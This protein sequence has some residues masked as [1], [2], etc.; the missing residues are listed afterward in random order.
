VA[1]H[2]PV[3]VGVGIGVAIAVAVAVGVAL[4]ALVAV[5]GGDRGSTF[6]CIRSSNAQNPAVTPTFDQVTT[7]NMGGS[8]CP[9]A[10]A[11]ATVET[12]Q[13]NKPAVDTLE[14]LILG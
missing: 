13:I 3:A 6:W 11:S 9:E 1:G 5:G 14:D 12:R 7:V 8:V 2:R 4:G 10:V